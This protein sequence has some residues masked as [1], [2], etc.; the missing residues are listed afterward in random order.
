MGFEQSKPAPW[1]SVSPSPLPHPPSPHSSHCH[2]HHHT[3]SLGPTIQPPPL[4]THTWPT[5]HTGRR[6]A[7]GRRRT[8]SSVTI[9]ILYVLAWALTHACHASQRESWLAPQPWSRRRAQ[10]GAETRDSSATF[11]LITNGCR[12]S[13]WETGLQGCDSPLGIRCRVVQ[14]CAQHADWWSALQWMIL[15]TGSTSS[16]LLSIEPWAAS[17]DAMTACELRWSRNGQRFFDHRYL[18]FYNSTQTSYIIPQGCNPHV[19][20]R[21]MV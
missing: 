1:H 12:A 10:K 8:P 17:S 16:E 19:T 5:S 6:S 4:P 11:H 15:C 2:P 7:A 13:F 21:C 14:L 18:V 9:P 20:C 3:G